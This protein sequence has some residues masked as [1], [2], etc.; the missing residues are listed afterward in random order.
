MKFEEGG[1][2]WTAT[3]SGLEAGAAQD[4]VSGLQE[5]GAIG[6]AIDGAKGIRSAV[7]DSVAAGVA[8]DLAS[9][10]IRISGY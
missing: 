5:S 6:R 2:L 4:K 7:L 8:V 1:E 9:R 10:S 3:V